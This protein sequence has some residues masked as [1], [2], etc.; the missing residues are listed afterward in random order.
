MFVPR[1]AMGIAIE[2]MHL[3]AGVL[4]GLHWV[5]VQKTYIFACRWTTVGF[6][7]MYVTRFPLSNVAESQHFCMQMNNCRV[8][9]HVC[10]KVCR[11]CG[12]VGD[13][14]RIKWCCRTHAFWSASVQLIGSAG[15]P[16]IV[17]SLSDSRCY[18][19]EISRVHKVRG[20]HCSTTSGTGGLG[21]TTGPQ[22]TV[23][24]TR[25]ACRDRDKVF[26]CGVLR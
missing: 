7:D 6:V 16:V 25:L 8:C 15:M 19:Y 20:L 11:V 24:T 26:T 17:C 18:S 12:H 4:Q 14:V 23:N 10:H 21:R 9:R 22:H 2:S 5:L 1:F 3:C 13:K